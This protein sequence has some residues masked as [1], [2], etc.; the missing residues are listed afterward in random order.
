MS[1]IL[2]LGLAAF[3]FWLTWYLRRVQLTWD[4]GEERLTR[5]GQRM[6]QA[7][8]ELAA[9]TALLEG[10]MGDIKAARRQTEQARRDE[11]T[12]RQQQKNTR[13]PHPLE[14][15]VP[16]EYSSSAKDTAWLIRFTPRFNTPFQ[17]PSQPLRPVLIWASG[18]HT[19]MSRARQIAGERQLAVL[20]LSPFG[21][22]S[23]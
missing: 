12:V 18:N 13:A 22:T 16:S 23:L 6:R 17:P 3:G 5:L 4:A 11:K 15:L 2:W 19:A 14:I 10:V 20:S 7:Q 1:A 21:E 8:G 9:E